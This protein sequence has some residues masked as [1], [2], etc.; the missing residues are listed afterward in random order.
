MRIHHAIPGWFM[1][2]TIVVAQSSFAGTTSVQ[3]RE[4]SSQPN[5]ATTTDRG[6]SVQLTDGAI[7]NFPMWT[8]REA[9]GWTATSPVTFSIDLHHGQARPNE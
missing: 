7:T 5:Y 6:D 9:V 4:I 2:A 8:K 1:L 3:V